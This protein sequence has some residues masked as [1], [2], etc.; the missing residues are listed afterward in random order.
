MSSIISPTPFSIRNKI[1]KNFLISKE[2]TFVLR[3]DSVKIFRRQ[4]LSALLR[5]DGAVRKDF[6]LKKKKKK[7][8]LHLS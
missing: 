8:I 3:N 6:P 2:F 1:F 7:T 5:P 4:P